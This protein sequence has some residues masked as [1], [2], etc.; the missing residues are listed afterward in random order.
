MGG[1]GGG[2]SH[3]QT[4]GGLE[5]QQTQRLEVDPPLWLCFCSGMDCNSHCHALYSMRA[6]R[7]GG[8]YRGSTAWQMSLQA[9]VD[10]KARMLDAC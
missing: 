1:G 8:V 3:I 5:A 4:S 6:G 10:S 9:L 7:G 2:Q